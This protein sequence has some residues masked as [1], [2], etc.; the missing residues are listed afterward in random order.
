MDS[1][2]AIMSEFSSDV[3]PYL[4]DEL[5]QVQ[6]LPAP[7]SLVSSVPSLQ[8]V[9]TPSNYPA[10]AVP[11]VF[12]TVALVRSP[13][14]MDAFLTYAGLYRLDL[15]TPRRSLDA[16]GYLPMTSPV[17]PQRPEGSLSLLGS[18]QSPRLRHFDPG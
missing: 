1:E 10:T 13:G 3:D 16:P 11:I 5:R 12:S 14:T 15:P 2:P 4:E 9:E 17:T 7:M 6:P 18:G 8:Q